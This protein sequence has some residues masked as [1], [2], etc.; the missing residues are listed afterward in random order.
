V[1]GNAFDK[2]GRVLL[3]DLKGSCPASDFDR[4]LVAQ[5]R[6]EP[7]RLLTHDANVALHGEPVL[8]V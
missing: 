2:D 1:D 6:A 5:A 7:L 8:R 4:L 3:A